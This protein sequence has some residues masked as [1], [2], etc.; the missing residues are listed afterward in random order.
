M[1]VDDYFRTPETVRP[2][3]I[4]FGVMRVADSPTPRHQ[5]AL[6]VRDRVRGAPDLAIEVL[7]PNP[8]I[9]Q[10]DERGVEDFLLPNGPGTTANRHETRANGCG[11]G[12][13]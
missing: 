5:S 9:G 10:T 8:R 1:T 12:L 3:E 6:V 4:I 11:R 7:P 2:M 13:E